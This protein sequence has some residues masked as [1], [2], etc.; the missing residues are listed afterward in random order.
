MDNRIEREK[1]FHNEAFSTN[2]R[3]SVDRFY[4]AASIALAFYEEKLLTSCSG[5]KILEYGCGPGSEA[6]MLAK[7]GAS[8]VGIDISDT[9][10]QQARQR[11]EAEK[12]DTNFLVMNAEKLHLEN[13]TFDMVCGSGIL[14][15]LDIDRAMSEISR[16]LKPNGSAV[17][18]EP[19]GH[20]PV[21]RLFRKLTP[22]LR[23]SDEHPLLMSDINLMRR[24]FAQS[25]TRCFCLMSL[26]ALPT[27]R[28]R[29]YKSILNLFSTIDDLLFKTAPFLR[30]YAWI[31]VLILSDPI[32]QSQRELRTDE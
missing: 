11:A 13:G 16:V 25:K 14:H 18:L 31:T 3:K 1:T 6:Y 32:L 19:L 15:H 30:R 22:H 4:S 10:I 26:L 17:F 12:T 28:F 7:H 27:N 21:V 29:W 24:Y 23:T 20:N 2:K 9:A 5:T 8:V